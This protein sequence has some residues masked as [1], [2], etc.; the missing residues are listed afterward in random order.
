M[1]AITSPKPEAEGMHE[2]RVF[3]EL[4]DN[5]IRWD[6]NDPVSVEAAKAAVEGIKAKFP[7]SIF[8]KMGRF[9][10]G[11]GEQIKDFDPSLGRILVV[12]QRAGG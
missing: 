12:P 5:P 9:G 10:R 8:F 2:L 7:G 4:G 11:R 3:C 6:P 1:G